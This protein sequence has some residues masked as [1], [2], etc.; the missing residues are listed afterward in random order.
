MK[1]I[2]ALSMLVAL[3]ALGM[4]CEPAVNTMNTNANSMN[5]NMMNTNMSTPMTT[6]SPEMDSNM[7][8]DRMD[9]NMNKMDRDKMDSNMNKMDR[10]KMNKDKMG[11]NTTMNRP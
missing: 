3:G 2:I 1:K 11:S 8:R 9:S 7:D 10:N 5:S 4:A 6:M